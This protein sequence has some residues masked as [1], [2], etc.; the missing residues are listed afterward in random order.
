MH[1]IPLM[2]Q[3]F[4]SDLSEDGRWAHF[5]GSL[6]ALRTLAGGREYVFYETP[7]GSSSILR[8]EAETLESQYM[9]KLFAKSLGRANEW[10][11][12]ASP[13][14]PLADEA[15]RQFVR[16]GYGDPI[17]ATNGIR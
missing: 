7:N 12:R 10:D 9:R 1:F 17:Y 4:D 2:H 13:N 3:P 11:W 5:E 15:W 6:Q 8:S 16:F 14:A